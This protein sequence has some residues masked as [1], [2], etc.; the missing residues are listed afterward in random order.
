MSYTKNSTSAGNYFNENPIWTFTDNLSKVVKSHTLKVGVYLEHNVK[1]QPSGSAYEGNYSFAPDTNNPL[2]TGNGYANAYL[3]YVDSYA[4]YTAAAQFNAVY[5][6]FEFYIQD[7]WKVNRRLT[8]DY[9]VRFYHQ[10][11]QNDTNHTFSNFSTAAY[12]RSAAPRLYVPGSRVGSGWPS[13]PAPVRWPRWPTSG[14]TFR[15]RATRP[16][17]W[18]LPGWAGFRRTPTTS[19]T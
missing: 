7:N 8:L 5:W 13:I 14:C 2:N 4:Q 10:G 1:V 17:G 19:A 3:G 11:P 12:S 15:T 18:A 9:G 6:N 16:T